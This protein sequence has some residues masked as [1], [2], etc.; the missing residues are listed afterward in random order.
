M[1]YYPQY[2]YDCGCTFVSAERHARCWSCNSENTINCYAEKLKSNKPKVGYMKKVKFH[3]RNTAKSEVM[4]HIKELKA[5]LNACHSNWVD[6]QKARKR[7]ALQVDALQ[8]EIKKLKASHGIQWNRLVYSPEKETDYFVIRK[9]AICKATF[10]QGNWYYDGC[11]IND[12]THFAEIN[13]PEK[14][15]GK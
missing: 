7:L 5:E 14:E 3:H 1:I 11:V 13:L 12:V 15:G 2:C 10:V 6:A 4:K 9:E 8:A